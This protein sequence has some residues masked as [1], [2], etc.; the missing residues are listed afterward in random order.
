MFASYH[1]VI[2]SFGLIINNSGFLADY[3]QQEF[4]ESPRLLAAVFSISWGN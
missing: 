4:Q 2:S 1:V 3:Q